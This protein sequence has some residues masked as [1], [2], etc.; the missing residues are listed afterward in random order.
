MHSLLRAKESFT[1]R[2]HLCHIVVVG[3]INYIMFGYLV[4]CDNASFSIGGPVNDDYQVIEITVD[5]T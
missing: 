2:T 3:S 5:Y 1:D 4:I